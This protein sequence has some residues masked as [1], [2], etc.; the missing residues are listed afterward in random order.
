M[1]QNIKS[2]L[3]LILQKLSE[4]RRVSK[5][6]KIEATTKIQIFPQFLPVNPMSSVPPNLM[7]TMKGD[8][9]PCTTLKHV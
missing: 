5:R 4:L 6:K 8:V 2:S 9:G 1:S 7:T 3:H